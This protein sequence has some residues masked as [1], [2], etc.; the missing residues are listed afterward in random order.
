MTLTA[1]KLLVLRMCL[2]IM[3]RQHK[4]DVFVYEKERKRQKREKR[5]EVFLV[6]EIVQYST[7]QHIG[8]IGDIRF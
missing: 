5:L 7:V 4:N 8:R 1:A 2:A 6:K 3:T